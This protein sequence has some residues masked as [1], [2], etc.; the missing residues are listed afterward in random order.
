MRPQ[1]K[2]QRTPLRLNIKRLKTLQSLHMRKLC[3]QV[4]MMLLK[5]RRSAYTITQ[6]K[7]LK[8]FVIR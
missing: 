8:L 3:G 4:R 2:Q 1:S 7:M 5:K 6:L